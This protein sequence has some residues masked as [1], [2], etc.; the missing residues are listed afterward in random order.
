[1]VDRRDIIYMK[2]IFLCV[3][4]ALICLCPALTAHGASAD[5]AL[6]ADIIEKLGDEQIAQTYARAKEGE[7]IAKG[8]KGTDLRGLQA[9]LNKLGAALEV[10]GNVGAMT[11]EA[12]A[13]AQQ[14]FAMPASET[15][16]RAEFEDLLINAYILQDPTTAGALLGPDYDKQVRYV[17]GSRHMETGDYFSAKKQ[18]DTLGDY[19]D[20]AARAAECVQ[21][22]PRDGA[23]VRDSAFDQIDCQLTLKTNRGAEQATYFKLYSGE[24]LVCGVFVAGTGEAVINL[25]KGTY[26]CKAGVGRNWYGPKEAFGTGEDAYYQALTFSDGAETALLREN[27]RYT[28]TLGAAEENNVDTH[29]VQPGDF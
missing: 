18:F 10:D 8:D 3:M 13:N 20:S 4:A 17:I 16:G 22:W 9:L 12:L 27:Y 28:L 24:V 2:R 21:Q 15:V 29:E 14:T 25:P 7:P 19:R 23:I 26:S 5:D 6:F 11:F 1:M